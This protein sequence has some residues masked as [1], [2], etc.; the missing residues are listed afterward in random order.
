MQSGENKDKCSHFDNCLL[1]SYFP[2]TLFFQLMHFYDIS[3]LLHKK[4]KTSISKLHKRGRYIM[5]K[6]TF[7][8]EQ[9]FVLG[10]KH[11]FWEKN[12]LE[13]FQTILHDKIIIV[14]YLM[15]TYKDIL[16]KNDM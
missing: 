5:N 1:Y 7:Y 13:I 11:L 8:K 6:N 3:R 12:K 10:N 16:I 14:G 2:R 4:S 15:K 9:S